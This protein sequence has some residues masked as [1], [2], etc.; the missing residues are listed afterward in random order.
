MEEV[1]ENIDVQRIVP[2][3]HL[4]EYLK[5]HNRT[6]DKLVDLKEQGKMKKELVEKELPEVFLTLRATIETIL[7]ENN[8]IDQTNEDKKDIQS[9][10]INE[11]K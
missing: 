2:W 9:A 6:V 11:L 10:M 8:I 4:Q 3:M 5:V 7:K 1:K